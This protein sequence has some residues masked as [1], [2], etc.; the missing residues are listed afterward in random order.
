MIVEEMDIL[1]TAFYRYDNEM[2]YYPNAALAT[3]SIGN[4][5]RS[6]DKMGDTVN[7]DVDVSTSF[8]SIEAL[9]AKIKE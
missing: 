7:F 1:K 9:K 4:F 2:I 5:N 8:E 6:P 3:N